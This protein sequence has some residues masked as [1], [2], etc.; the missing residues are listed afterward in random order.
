MEGFW[1]VMT[2]VIVC[3]AASAGAL[4]WCKRKGQLGEL[5]H[6][7]RLR[8]RDIFPHNPPLGRAGKSKVA[9]KSKV[10]A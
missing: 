3:V 5:E 10:T 7:C 1:M 4:A 2:V 6:A 9:I 8:W